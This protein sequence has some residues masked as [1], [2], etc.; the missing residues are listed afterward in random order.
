M[1]EMKELKSEAYDCLAQIEA[2]Q[3]KLNVVTAKIKE[4]GEKAE[5]KTE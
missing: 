5:P 2:W 1:D 3:K 4:L